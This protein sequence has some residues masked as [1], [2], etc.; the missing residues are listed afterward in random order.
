MLL[1]NILV[2]MIY[3][4]DGMQFTKTTLKN[5]TFSWLNDNDIYDAIRNTVEPDL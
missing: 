2:Q 5:K 4:N 3:S 1:E